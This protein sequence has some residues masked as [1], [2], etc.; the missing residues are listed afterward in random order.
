MRCNTD[1]RSMAAT[2]R[3]TTTFSKTSTLLHSTSHRIGDPSD[4]EL[5]WRAKNVSFDTFVGLD[6]QFLV[7]AGVDATIEQLQRQ[8]LNEAADYIKGC[9][10]SGDF[11]ALDEWFIGR[12]AYF[13]EE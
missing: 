12:I 6:V 8:E 3:W 13:A 10:R 5:L 4:S 9:A 7:G 11:D 2:R 1:V